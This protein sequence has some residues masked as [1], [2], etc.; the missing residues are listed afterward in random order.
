M[1]VKKE[2][3]Y[4]FKEF[5]VVGVLHRSHAIVI[6]GREL[7]VPLS[8]A[9]EMTGVFPVFENLDAAKK[10]AGEETVILRAQMKVKKP[11]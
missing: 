11:N 7:P 5:F 1:G 9:E 2:P 6:F 8:W 4:E 3:E 10:Y